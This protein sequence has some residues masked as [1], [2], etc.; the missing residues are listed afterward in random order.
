MLNWNSTNFLGHLDKEKKMQ[1]CYWLES[2]VT[3]SNIFATRCSHSF[4]LEEASINQLP[5]SSGCLRLCNKK[6]SSSQLQDNIP[7]FNVSHLRKL[8]LGAAGKQGPLL[9]YSKIRPALLSSHANNKPHSIQKGAP[10]LQFTILYRVSPSRA[11]IG[12]QEYF[13]MS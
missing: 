13:R 8:A 5:G 6:R 7:C 9:I 4:N 2:E 3:P 10:H 11:N 12:V 1:L